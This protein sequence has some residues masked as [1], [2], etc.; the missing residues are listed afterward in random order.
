LEPEKGDIEKV[1]KFIAENQKEIDEASKIVNDTI[2]QIQ[3]KL[4]KASLKNIER[5]KA[6]EIACRYVVD[7]A[8]ELYQDYTDINP[9]HCRKKD[10]PQKSRKTPEYI[11]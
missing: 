7:P 4:G 2:N 9:I 5:I 1:R 8:M 10:E 3:K 11:G 6:L